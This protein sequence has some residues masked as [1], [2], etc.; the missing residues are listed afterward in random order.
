MKR[1]AP[2]ADRR[3]TRDINPRKMHEEAQMVRRVKA[4]LSQRTVIQN[5]DE[6]MQLSYKCEP[7]PSMN[8]N[9]GSKTLTNHQSTTSI[10][11]TVSISKENIV[12]IELCVYFEIL[13]GLI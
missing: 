10:T 4:Y 11:S 7:D 5:E 9:S 2:H 13:T 8:Q 3:K 12:K 1:H 6:L